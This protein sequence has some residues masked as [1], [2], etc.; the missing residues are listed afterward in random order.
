MA[1]GNTNPL[2]MS[3]EDFLNLQSPDQ[4]PTEGEQED[5]PVQEEQ[6]DPPVSEEE[7]GNDDTAEGEE[8][9]EENPEDPPTDGEDGDDAEEDEPEAGA[10]GTQE[11]SS[12]GEDPAE[13]SDKAEDPDPKDKKKD[14]PDTKEGEADD[15]SGLP[16]QAE[17]AAFYQKIMAPFKANGR[18]IKVNNAEEALSLMQMGANYTK[19]MQD[20]QPHRKVLMMLEDQ[21]LLDQAKLGYL[22]DL[23]KGDK[24]AVTKLLKD[25]GIDPMDIDTESDPQYLGSDH[26]VSDEQ[27]NFREVLSDI[28]GTDHGKETLTTIE[29]DWDTASK[30]ALWASPEIMRLIDEQR[31]NGI[32]GQIT[33]EIDRQRTLGA[34]PANTPFLEAYQQV[35]R[36]LFSQGEPDTEQPANPGPAPRVKVAEK[37]A[38]PKPKVTNGDKASA[39]APSRSTPRKSQKLVNPLEMSDEEF[40]KISGIQ[41]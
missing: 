3:D 37:V 29:K 17:L 12:E 27:A 40:A 23:H 7:P 20:I 15:N 6:E 18:E 8:E 33:T 19:K 38:K 1:D 11:K 28:A 41:L 14:E 39:A 35:G 2:E 32:Y 30:E 31:E 5:P 13:G 10:A 36:Q 4:L 21:G 26:Q 24:A 34:I 25:K 16:D 9:G 22:V